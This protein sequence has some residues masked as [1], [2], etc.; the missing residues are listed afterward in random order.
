MTTPNVTQTI[1]PV[2]R[3]P[4]P[5]HGI[6]EEGTD[7]LRDIHHE[8]TLM[9]DHYS[10]RVYRQIDGVHVPPICQ[11]GETPFI[12]QLDDFVYKSICHNGPLLAPGAKR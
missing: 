10:P 2:E 11:G 8:L 6:I 4:N 7:A 9:P 5:L 1:Q 3:R 12:I